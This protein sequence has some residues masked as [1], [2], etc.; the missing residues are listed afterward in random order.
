M[1]IAHVYVRT[2]RTA[3]YVP[4]R[5]EVTTYVGVRERYSSA[6]KQRVSKSHYRD[7]VTPSYCTER[8]RPLPP[9]NVDPHRRGTAD[10]RG[11]V[12]VA[13]PSCFV[14]RGSANSG[15]RLRA[16]DPN[17]TFIAHQCDPKVNRIKMSTLRRRTLHRSARVKGRRHYNS[18]GFRRSRHTLAR[19]HTECMNIFAKYYTL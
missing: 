9:G 18:Q 1:H 14:P 8:T 16:L 6:R 3:R 2:V 10:E 12:F 7:V 13:T 4:A 15:C 17:A 11:R 19:M 5:G